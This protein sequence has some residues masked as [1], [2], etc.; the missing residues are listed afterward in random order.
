MKNI[1]FSF[2]ILTLILTSCKK[3]EDNNNNN[4]SI[5]YQQK[6]LGNWSVS[7]ITEQYRAGYFLN[8]VKHYT[9]ID[10]EIYTYY[11]DSHNYIFKGG[12]NNQVIVMQGE[13]S[14]TLSYDLNGNK[15]EIYENYYGNNYFHSNWEISI[16]NNSNFEV[17]YDDFYP[18]NNPNDT[19]W[20]SCYQ[21][22]INMN[23]VQ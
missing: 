18:G 22:E 14:D 10:P 1:F 8:G 5:N 6:I 12:S 19:I 16:V 4:S 11:P 7:Q 17:I 23:K 13:Y 15:I 2:L 20:F 3:E 9:D 21:G